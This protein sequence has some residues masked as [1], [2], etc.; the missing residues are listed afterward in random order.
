MDKKAV[1]IILYTIFTSLILL[2]FNIY[3]ARKDE[4]VVIPTQLKPERMKLLEKI[5]NEKIITEETS[6]LLKEM[7]S[8]KDDFIN[9]PP[10]DI[11]KMSR[12]IL[13]PMGVT[14][15]DFETIY[16]SANVVTTLVFVDKLG[17]PWTLEKHTVSSP[18]KIFPEVI[19][20]NMMT[21]S[22]KVRRGNGNMTL[23]FKDAFPINIDWKISEVKVDNVTEIKLDGYGNRSPKDGGIRIHVGGN[24]VAPKYDSNINSTMLS[25]NTPFGFKNK[26]VYNQFEE[27]ENGFKIWLSDD[28]QFLYT[29]TIHKVLYPPI[30]F[31]KKSGDKKTKVY[32]T[33]VSPRITVIKDGKLL[34]LKIDNK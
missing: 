6:D 34:K 27:V 8:D 24:T 3:A 25:G 1:N 12:S 17:N 18:S 19:N 33:N 23:F 26:V 30:L 21:F 9:N 15:G 5:A 4:Q 13:I 10:I 31:V 32:K 28:N 29:R 2:S 14:D 16:L 22:P 20:A 11:E 7:L